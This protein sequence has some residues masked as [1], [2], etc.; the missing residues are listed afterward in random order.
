MSMLSLS[1]VV[2]FEKTYTAF[3]DWLDM[4]KGE[5]KR[6]QERL[7]SEISKFSNWVDSNGAPTYL[8]KGVNKTGWERQRNG[9]VGGVYLFPELTVHTVG[10]M[11]LK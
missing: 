3:E 5:K 9:L 11:A 6:H 2:I 7:S 4:A 10:E 1:S 8:G